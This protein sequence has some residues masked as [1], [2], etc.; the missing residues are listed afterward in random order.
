MAFYFWEKKKRQTYL[1]SVFYA[2]DNAIYVDDAGY[3]AVYAV[4][5]AAE[6][7]A[8][9]TDARAAVRA[10]AY[11][12]DTR[13]SN[14]AY[15]FRAAA[16]AARAANTSN[17]NLKPQILNDINTSKEVT[18]DS[19]SFYGDIWTTFQKALE[20]E[21][22]AYWGQLYKTIFENDFK[23]DQE[24]LKRESMFLKKSES[25]EPQ[26]WRVI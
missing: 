2:L 22:C 14:S 4:Y 6:A 7:A 17:L 24:A 9:G 8:Y 16:Y 23:L 19:I 1:Y 18:F 11:A 12:I 20:A 13:Y 10:T 21:G 26:L 15:A 5:A 25:K 3:G